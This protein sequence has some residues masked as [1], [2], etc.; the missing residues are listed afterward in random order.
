MMGQSLSIP[1]PSWKSSERSPRGSNLSNLNGSMILP[2]EILDGILE[3]VPTSPMSGQS[4]LIACALVA[5]WWT[6]PS[7]RRLSPSVLINTSNYQRWMNGV[8]SSRSKAQLLEH[9]R[10]LSLNQLQMRGLSQDHGQY[11]P[12][13]CNVRGLKLF[14]AEVKH[15]SEAQFQPCFSGFRGTLTYPFIDYIFAS[16][17]AF[18][19]L[20]DYFPNLRTL[21]LRMY[22]LGRDEGPVPPFSRPPRGRLHVHPSSGDPSELLSR[23]A[24]LDLEYEVLVIEP[25]TSRYLDRPRFLESA[26]QI[27]PNT[28]KYLTMTDELQS[29]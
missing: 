27:S 6:G 14:S 11:L 3:H 20:V 21:E 4:T 1:P 8:V 5:T 26:L 13:L 19:A 23:F 24:K 2:P 28:V 17:G 10:W 16:F 22:G 29:E 12:A 25:L 7:Q 15:I 9:V 18:V